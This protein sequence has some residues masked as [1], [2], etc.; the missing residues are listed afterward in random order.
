MGSLSV[1]RFPA[2]RIEAPGDFLAGYRTALAV[3][4]AAVDAAAFARAAALLQDAVARGATL[5]LC[6]NG[7]SA[8]IANHAVCDFAKGAAEDSGLAPRI[9]S[10][11]AGEAL[12]T[13]LANDI[14]YA[15]V[16]ARPLRALGRPGDVLIAIS[17]SGASENV[18]GAIACARAQGLAVLAL[19]GFDGGPAARQSD[20]SL[21]VPAR[22]YGVVE[23]AH[24]ALLH[25]LAQ[26][27][28]QAAMPPDQVPRSR[29]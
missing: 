18:L 6:G 26:Y 4:L 11:V 25:A 24:Q 10:L 7:G 27:L 22:N 28:R 20:L 13:A 12:L 29:F 16:F 1:G 3:A 9:V 17:A 15:E 21:H 8:A 5:F 19:T 14:G 23:D 2:A